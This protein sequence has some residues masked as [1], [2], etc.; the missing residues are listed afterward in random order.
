MNLSNE[1][2]GRKLREQKKNK[3]NYEPVEHSRSLTQ[4]RTFSHNFHV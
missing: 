2:R 4:N 1:K 3:S